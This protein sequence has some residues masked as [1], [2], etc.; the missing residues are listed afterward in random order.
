MGDAMEQRRTLGAK[1]VYRYKKTDDRV[2]K[3]DN[4]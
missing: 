4:K 3:R 1:S 2:S